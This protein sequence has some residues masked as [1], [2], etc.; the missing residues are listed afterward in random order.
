MSQIYPNC[1]RPDSALGGPA[2]IQ[3]TRVKYTVTS[4]YLGNSYC[5]VSVA[6]PF[7]FPDANYTINMTIEQP[8]GAGTSFYL[9]TVFGKTASGFNVVATLANIPIGADSPTIGD[10]ITIHVTATHD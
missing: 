8:E 10:V 9:G 5:N 2:P 7:A 3:T 1:Q 4:T 6:L